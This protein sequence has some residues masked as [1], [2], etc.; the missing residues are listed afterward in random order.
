MTAIRTRAFV[1]EDYERA[2]A[3]WREM[4][5]I[6][7]CEGDAREEIGRYLQRNPGLSRVAESEGEMVGAVLCGHDGRRGYIYHLAVATSFR[8]RG[9]GKAMLDDCV[10][11]LADAGISRALLL[12]ASENASGHEF[13]LRQGWEDIDAL[14]MALEVRG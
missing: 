1:I 5:G 14:A 10:R 9:V 8:G 13:W 2:L 6:E 3:L 12:V 11:G 4:E 7:I